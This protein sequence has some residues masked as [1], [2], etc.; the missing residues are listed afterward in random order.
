[1]KKGEWISQRTYRH[2]AEAQTADG[3]GQRRGGGVGLEDVGKGDGMGT[4][5]IVSTIK[6]I[7][8]SSLPIVKQL[9]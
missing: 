8:P 3:D 9:I 2:N 4:Y 1:M 7:F 6:N 5:A